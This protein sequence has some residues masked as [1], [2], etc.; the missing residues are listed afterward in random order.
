MT[1]LGPAIGW[2]DPATGKTHSLDHYKPEHANHLDSHKA[3]WRLAFAPELSPQ[4]P[5]GGSQ[6]GPVTFKPLCNCPV[7][8]WEDCEHTRGN[9]P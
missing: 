1:T 8:A 7:L 5:P 6:T 2:Y 3:G 4:M 9:K